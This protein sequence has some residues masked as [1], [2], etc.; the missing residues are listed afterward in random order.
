M[1]KF[2][3]LYLLLFVW[4]IHQLIGGIAFFL[5][6]IILVI[7]QRK[8]YKI[9][10]IIIALFFSFTYMINAESNCENGEYIGFV[11]ESRDNYYIFSS[12]LVDYYVYE[13][14]NELENGDL[15]VIKAKRQNLSFISLESEFDFQDYLSK[16][17]VK[18]ELKVEYKKIVI[19]SIIK[20]KLVKKTILSKFND[21]QKRI[22]NTVIF[23]AYEDK[24][25][26][27]NLIVL[28]ESSGLLFY[29]L[30]KILKR[31]FNR[32]LNDKK[33]NI[34]TYIFLMPIL[35]LTSFRISI[36][37]TYLLSFCKDYKIKVKK[38][39]IYNALLLLMIFKN[40]LY[41]KSAS[42]YLVFF[43][44]FIGTYLKES[45]SAFPIKYNDIVTALFF[46]IV[47]KPVYL[48][49]FEKISL[50]S[51]LYI[52]LFKEIF[53]VL[54]LLLLIIVF[55][56]ILNILLNP[57]VNIY[58][59][60]INFFIVLNFNITY[61]YHLYFAVTIYIVL[62][63]CMIMTLE[64]NN[65]KKG[66]KILCIMNV[67]LFISSSNFLSNNDS[68]I[69]F[70]NVGQGDCILIHD[71]KTNVLI[72]TGGNIKKDIANAVLIPYLK[73][74]NIYKINH[75]FLS[76]DDYDHS[77]ALDSLMKNFKIL[78][79]VKG[80]DFKNYI[81]NNLHFANLNIFGDGSLNNDDSSVLKIKFYSKTYIFCGDISKD[82]EMKI[83][84]HFDVK[85]DI[86]KL[87]HH[88]SNT[89]SCLEF[90]KAVSPKEAVISVGKN[91][92]YNHPSIEV[93]NRLK[94]LNI[95]CR[96]IDVEGSIVYKEN[97]HS[98]FGM[99]FYF[100]EVKCEISYNEKGE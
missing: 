38:E 50:F 61:S 35:F 99:Y 44:P 3:F 4:L 63:I 54:Y 25:S 82:I 14:D 21:N 41:L 24:I 55:F 58:N 90:L 40:P 66:I 65:L 1:K 96:R 9:D 57:L 27:T 60:F 74:L 31:I 86:L 70:I 95:K 5:F 18:Y 89:S 71:R 75:I 53:A 88:G 87:A 23:N 77:G 10:I 46:D 43:I 67:M 56:P 97:N 33:T 94:L 19:Q 2:L 37:K 42:F 49:F 15:L 100:F 48:I 13:K 80:S 91:N 98:F 72:D 73:K 92:S 16:K 45:I 68:F 93:I 85:A 11:K 47:Y 84:E 81:V 51:F 8:I 22:I 20:T 26:Q 79:Y 12:D 29:T 32:F 30:I 59:F 62:L 76:H 78:S 69:S 34:C 64:R 36:L 83:I 7:K 28:F 17:N 52:Y 6:L 39:Q